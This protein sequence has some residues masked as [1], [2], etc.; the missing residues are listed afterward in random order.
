[1]WMAP[2]ITGAWK[3]LPITLP[4]SDDILEEFGEWWLVKTS[5]VEHYPPRPEAPVPWDEDIESAD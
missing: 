3:Q 2:D 5:V 1:M 4:Y